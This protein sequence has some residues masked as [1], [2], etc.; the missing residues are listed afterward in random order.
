MVIAMPIRVTSRRSTTAPSV[1]KPGVTPFGLPVVPAGWVQKEPGVS[2]CMI[3]K[4][5]ERFLEQCLA[6]VADMVDEICI[7]DTGSTDATVAIAQRFGARV[8]HREWRNDFAWARNEALAMAT[9]RWIFVLD[10]DEVVLPESREALTV[11]KNA[12]AYNVGVWV[13]CFNKADDYQGTG[14]MSHA[15]VR[16]LPNHPRIKYRGMIHE[17]VAMD[18]NPNGIAA[19]P[20]PLAIEH[21]GYLKDIVAER[22]K[23]ERN[24]EIV[25][26]AIEKEPLDPF[27][28]FNLGMTAHLMGREDDAIDG[29]ERMRELNGDQPRGFIPNG[30][31]TLADIYTEKKK[32]PEKGLAI[33]QQCLQFSPHYANAHF[34]V[35]K[36][37][38][39]MKRYEEAR[40]AYR[41]AIAD[42]A[43]VTQQFVVDDEVP[44]WKAQCEIGTTYVLQGDDVRA[45]EW[46]DKGIANR[47]TAQPVRI[48]RA[49]AIERLGRFDEAERAFA[50][51]FEEF[52]DDPTAAHY[53]NYLLRR[54][55]NARALEVIE[56]CYENLSPAGAATM[57]A[58]AAAVCQRNGLPDAR[59]YL[60]AAAK[61]VPGSAEVL[62]PLEAIY[63][64][65]GEDRALEELL[66][67]EES[68]PPQ[69]Q[70]D[71]LRR[72]HRR[73]S[74]NRFD[75]ALALARTGLDL[76]DD[77][78]LHYNAAIAA[79]NLERKHDAVR[80]LDAVGPEHEATYVQAEYLKA[81][82]LRDLGELQI[83]L[84]AVERLLQVHPTQ[85]DALI[86]RAALLEQMG[87]AAEAEQLLTAAMPHDR[88]RVAVE[89]AG[90][91]LR[92][93]RIAEAKRIAE[94][95]L[96]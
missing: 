78:F 8:E 45:I 16:V 88:H 86:L 42:G 66:A 38:V 43:Y 51:L 79:V 95:A 80:H 44:V 19:V 29:F 32:Q 82:I 6:S 73:L 23:A 68:T 33:A 85:V 93:G 57:L 53:V 48:N 47:P 72:S 58:A 30:L 17:F 67:R 65:S 10:A 39:E 62:N 22:N 34:A 13:R 36:A 84:A 83:A 11:L 92:G 69:V 87:R 55:A 25:K 59:R 28:W 26:A 81:V 54:G 27:H 76:G 60:E 46:F 37:L 5:E 71:Y 9:K 75:E 18:E 4:N 15:L 90:L 70:A 14:A 50:D 21:H 52:A 96:S 3:V 49:R 20:S 24:L 1:Q 12:P 89:L 77:P 41:E 63:R 7:V 35:G 56:R 2:L 40:D 31:A 74:E 91:Y 94:A 61:L 64:E